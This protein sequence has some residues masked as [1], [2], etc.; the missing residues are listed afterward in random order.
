MNIEFLDPPVSDQNGGVVVRADVGGQIVICHF[1]QEALQ[2]VNPH[3]KTLSP[4]EQYG[5]SEL[6]LKTV[7][8]RLIREGKVQNG[9]VFVGTN[10]VRP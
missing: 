2:D 7:A 5:T 9:Q 3:M 4:I 8:E 6:K 10:D 1:T